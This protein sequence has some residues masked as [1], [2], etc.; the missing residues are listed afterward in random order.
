M[1]PDADTATSTKMQISGCGQDAGA[2]RFVQSTI[3]RSFEFM[4]RRSLP[5]RESSAASDGE[6]SS[7]EAAPN[8]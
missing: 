6:A 8:A 3:S 7:G 4:A 5:L 1:I 2:E